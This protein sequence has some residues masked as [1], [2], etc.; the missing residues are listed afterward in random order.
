ME[1][2]QN[3]VMGQILALANSFKR[4]TSSFT[5]GENLSP[6]QGRVLH[7]ILGVSKDE[8]FQKDIEEEFYIR[9]SSATE[10]LKGLELNGF[11][12]RESVEY[13]SRLKKITATEKALSYK[14]T[15]K[16]DMD[17]MQSLL[18]KGILEED[19]E[20]FSKVVKQMFINME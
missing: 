17:K 4:K 15:V 2:T 8:I 12:K 20:V 16:D 7:Y 1:N 11:I 6:S 18:T 19:L 14:K 13:D 10:I 5:V 3:F 9:P